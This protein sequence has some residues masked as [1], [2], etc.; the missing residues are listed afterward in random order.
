MTRY[1]PNHPAVQDYMRRHTPPPRTPLRHR[2]LSGLGLC[3]MAGSL[4]MVA[5]YAEHNTPLWVALPS[6]LCVMFVGFGLA[7]GGSRDDLS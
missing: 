4:P 2:L 6:W 7:S 1:S 3:L 5:W